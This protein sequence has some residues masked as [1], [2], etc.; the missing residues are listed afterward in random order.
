MWDSIMKAVAGAAVSSFFGGG[1]DS[2][3]DLYSSPEQLNLQKYS[4]GRGMG[5]TQITPAEKTPMPAA[6]DY[7]LFV[8]QWE[9][10]LTSYQRGKR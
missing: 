2:S 7:N 1:G 10:Y 9:N 3:D 6:S 8:Q 4:P 5:R